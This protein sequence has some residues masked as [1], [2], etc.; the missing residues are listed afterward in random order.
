MKGQLLSYPLA[1]I[2]TSRANICISR[3]TKYRLKA[4]TILDEDIQK[5]TSTL[6]SEMFCVIQGSFKRGENIS[7]DLKICTFFHTYR[8]YS[9][10]VSIVYSIYLKDNGLKPQLQPQQQGIA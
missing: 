2:H 7:L 1:S 10:C 5:A 6:N 3:C 4:R 8:H 9:I